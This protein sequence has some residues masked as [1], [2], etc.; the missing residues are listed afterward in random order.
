MALG[1][2]GVI[3]RSRQSLWFAT[4]SRDARRPDA[5]RMA[6]F[7]AETYL[8]RERA[9]EL[10]GIT[11][12][13]RDAL[14]VRHLFSYFVADD[15]T[16]FHWFQAPSPDAVRRVL[17]RVGLS[18]DRVVEADPIGDARPSPELD[19]ASSVSERS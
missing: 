15:E 11:Q 9:S 7:L 18:A 12:R 17:E 19:G 1:R 4:L 8:S 2:R 5:P 10:E 3:R 13:L 16:A 14:P 6:I